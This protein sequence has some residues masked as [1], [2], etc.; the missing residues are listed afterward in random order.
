MDTKIIVMES[1]GVYWVA[2]FEVLEP[3]GLEIILA[4]ASEALSVAG[5][6]PCTELATLLHACG[7]LRAS[8]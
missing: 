6:K 5:C 4:N 8:F 3:L 7:L 1:T 2:A